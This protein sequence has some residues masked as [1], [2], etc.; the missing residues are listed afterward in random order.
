MDN[1]IPKFGREKTRTLIQQAF[2]DWAK[3]APL[4]FRE[5]PGDDSAEFVIRFVGGDHQDG[6]PFDGPAGTLAHAF[7]PKDGRIHFDETEDWTD[8]LVFSV[9]QADLFGNKSCRLGMLM[10]LDSIFG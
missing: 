4:K 7:F 2:D 1:D 5:S 3:Y 10:V 9:S 8:K 6:Y